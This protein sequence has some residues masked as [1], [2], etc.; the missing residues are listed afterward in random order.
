MLF[1]SHNCDNHAVWEAD[2]RLACFR[3]GTLTDAEFVRAGGLSQECLSILYY[4][5]VR[6]AVSAFNDNV[7]IPV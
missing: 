2:N 5:M 6:L 1:C 7:I 4:K 3:D